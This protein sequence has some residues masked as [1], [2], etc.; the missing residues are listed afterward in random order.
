MLRFLANVIEQLDVALE[1]LTK[2]DANNA[3]F[4]LMLTDNVVELMLHQLAKDKKDELKIC[5]YKREEF[6]HPAALA[7]ALGR[8]FE[9]K[10]KF[11][12]IIGTVPDEISETISILHSFRN[13]VYHIGLQHEAVLPTLATFYF[14]VACDFLQNYSPR[15]LS[16]GSNQRL[17][18]AQ[19][20]S[21]VATAVSPA[22]P[23]N[24]NWHALALARR[25]VSFRRQLRR[26]SPSIW[27]RWSNSRIFALI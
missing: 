11:A 15:G 2:S 9:S 21:L 27:R 22:Q 20:S 6:R 3:R 4:G 18:E 16:W 8:N 14:K 1:H 7:K 23:S 13:E 5:S 12:K 25:P 19:K 17:P 24:I 26:F 10:V